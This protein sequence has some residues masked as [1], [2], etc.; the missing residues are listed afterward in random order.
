[1]RSSRG[2]G[3]VALGAIV[4]AAISFAVVDITAGGC[5][6]SCG[7]DVPV[8][9]ITFAAL[10]SLALLVSVLPAVT[11]IVEA[12]QSNRSASAEAD[13]ELARLARPSRGIAED[14]L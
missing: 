6:A 13:R 3:A 8:V 11:W 12:V 4:I 9:A 5:D 10:G 7:A 14:D 1:M 2:L